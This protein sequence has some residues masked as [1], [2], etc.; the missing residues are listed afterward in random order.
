MTVYIIRHGE[1]LANLHKDLPLRPAYRGIADTD[2]PLTQL[3]FLQAVEAGRI[4]A[5]K[6]D[7]EKRHERKLVVLRSPFLRTAQTTE[8]LLYGLGLDDVQ[9]QESENLREQDFGLFSGITDR[10]ILR[11]KWPQEAQ[12]FERERQNPATIHTATPPGGESRADVVE[13]AKSFVATHEALFSDPNTDVIIVGHGLVNR[14]VELCLR[15]MD[16][17]EG[18]MW[19]AEQQNPMNCAIREL[20]GDY[21]HG[22]TARYIHEGMRRPKHLRAEEMTRPYVS[23]RE[24]LTGTPA[25]G[26]QELAHVFGRVGHGG[27]GWRALCDRYGDA[28]GMQV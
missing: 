13:R 10:A 26:R 22:Y 15:R 28:A 19:L 1:S 6:W 17:Q 14:A 12:R 24:S 4:L 18:A 7:D 9:G 5:R 8:G 16:E 27:D 21:Q 2:V 25:A 23:V 20:E 3:G 11:E